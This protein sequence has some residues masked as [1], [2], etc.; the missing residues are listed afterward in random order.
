LNWH[1]RETITG[2][3][4]PQADAADPMI[5]VSGRSILF[6]IIKPRHSAAS[7]LR[8]SGKH[9][10]QFYAFLAFGARITSPRAAPR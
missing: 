6:S 5:S 4:G 10:R 2:S 3:F 7:F 9:S 8:C 1:A